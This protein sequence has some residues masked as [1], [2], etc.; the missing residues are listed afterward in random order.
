MA[1]EHY[2]SPYAPD[3]RTRRS[4]MAAQA[5][6]KTMDEV[7]Q[8]DSRIKPNFDNES[9]SGALGTITV[10]I[11][12]LCLQGAKGWDE[13]QVLMPE[14]PRVSE[15]LFGGASIAPIVGNDRAVC[16][17]PWFEGYDV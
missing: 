17:S 11:E 7:Y 13:K 8:H 1:S 10:S 16:D 6:N 15:R 9:F 3:E 14:V 12:G 5:Y 2:I 4:V